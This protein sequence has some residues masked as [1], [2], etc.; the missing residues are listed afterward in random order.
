MNLQKSMMN[1]TRERTE[2]HTADSLE[3][4]ILWSFVLKENLNGVLLAVDDI[5]QRTKH[6]HPDST[7]YL[8]YARRDYRQKSQLLSQSGL[9]VWHL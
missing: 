1:M 6:A 3:D 9:R 2:R 5:C 7:Q 4:N 8:T